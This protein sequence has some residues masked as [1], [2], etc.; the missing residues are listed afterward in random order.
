MPQH[1]RITP[2]GGTYPCAACGR[3]IYRDDGHCRT[4][5]CPNRVPDDLI[6]PAR[7]AALAQWRELRAASRKRTD[8]SHE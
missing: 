2:A 5:T 6:K 7:D 8:S 4:V 3:P 1:S